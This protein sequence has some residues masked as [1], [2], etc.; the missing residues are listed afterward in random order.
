MYKLAS[1][2][3]LLLLALWLAAPLSA[4]A[5]PMA[6]VANLGVSAPLHTLPPS[7]TPTALSTVPAR[8]WRLASSWRLPLLC[9]GDC[10]D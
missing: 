1:R 9:S 4:G 3:A 10:S 5:A 2:E 6:R 7:A 8:A